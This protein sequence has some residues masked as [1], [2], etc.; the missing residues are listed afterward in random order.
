VGAITD[1]RD[2]ALLEELEA[3]A[4]SIPEGAGAAALARLVRA[5][6]LVDSNVSPELVLDV[7]LLRWPRAAAAA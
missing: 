3:A 5:T 2:V 7:L 4:R 6:E 1:V